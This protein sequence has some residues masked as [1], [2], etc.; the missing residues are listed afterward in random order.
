[1]SGIEGT[2]VN[3]NVPD[4]LLKMLFSD[5]VN[6]CF[7]IHL[8]SWPFECYISIL[9]NN[10]DLGRHN[11]SFVKRGGVGLH[12]W[13]VDGNLAP[14]RTETDCAHG[15]MGD[16]TR[17]WILSSQGT[18]LAMASYPRGAGLSPRTN[19]AWRF[20]SIFNRHG[21]FCGRS[22][23]Q[24]FVDAHRTLK[25]E[26][27]AQWGT[28]DPQSRVQQCGTRSFFCWPPSVSSKVG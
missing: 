5:D 21:F 1:M 12:E 22:C 17:T 10:I 25:E 23:D 24:G 4:S 6:K 3:C 2:T 18:Q 19:T 26:K 11:P 16:N 8:L 28:R 9:C 14:C 27:T 13:P 15:R 20:C 7:P